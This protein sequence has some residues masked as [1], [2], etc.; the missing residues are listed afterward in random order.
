[1]LAP[2]IHIERGVRHISETHKSRVYR[3]RIA[4]RVIQP[5]VGAEYQAACLAAG[6]RPPS[7]RYP[8]PRA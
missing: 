3:N 6:L 2:P 1:M 5:G 8:S 7:L 4:Y